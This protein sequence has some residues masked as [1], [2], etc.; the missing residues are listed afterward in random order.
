MNH[1]SDCDDNRLR[2]TASRKTDLVKNLAQP[3][4][5]GQ[6]ILRYTYFAEKGMC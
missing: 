5:E 6:V 1:D 2:E 4:L 3:L